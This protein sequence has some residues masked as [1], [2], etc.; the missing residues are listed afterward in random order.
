MR[1]KFCDK[2]VYG[3][4][5]MTIPGEGISHQKCFQANEVMKRTF[6]HLDIGALNDQELTD[7]KDLVLAEENSRKKPESEGDIEL[8]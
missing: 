8:F 7:L 6:Q 1:C 2:P 5:G 3:R 4:G